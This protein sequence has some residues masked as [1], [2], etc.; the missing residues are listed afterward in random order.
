M[1]IF[2]KKDNSA[3]QGTVKKVA[4][5]DDAKRAINKTSMK[6]LYSDGNKN[7]KSTNKTEKSEKKI[8]SKFG[9]AYKVLVKPLVTEKASNLGAQNKYIFEVSVDANKIEVAKAM[10][11][12]Y[13]V[14][15]I[16]VNILN[17]KGKK[18]RHGRTVGRRKDWRKAVITLKKGDSIKVYEGV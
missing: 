18:T 8:S 15:P 10:Q 6:D 14:Q 2:S 4:K 13:G 11:E 3:K 9:N 17:I 12:V 5:D 7:L 16:S 1:G